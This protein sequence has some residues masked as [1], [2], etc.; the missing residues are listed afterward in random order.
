MALCRK[1]RVRCRR[2]GAATVEA[3][4]VLPFIVLLILGTCDQGQLII[5]SQTVSDASRE[6][7]RFAARYSTN[8]VA[9][10]D[11][12]AKA[13]LADFPSTAITTNVADAKG[14][15][16]PSGDLTSIPTGESVKVEVI[17]DYDSVRWLAFLPFLDNR[18]ITTATT[19][20]RE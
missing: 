1:K 8:T 11:S 6:A 19:M 14:N 13:Y 16:I 7:A 5:V 12:A 9:E 2:R 17:V 20:R 18:A 3:A 10:V 4:A 15:A